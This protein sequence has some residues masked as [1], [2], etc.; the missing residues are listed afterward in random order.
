MLPPLTPACI[1]AECRFCICSCRARAPPRACAARAEHMAAAATMAPLPADAPNGEELRARGFGDD[2]EL[3]LPLPEDFS[4]D[5][6]DDDGADSEAG[7]DAVAGDVACEVAADAGCEGSAA[8]EPE[9]AWNWEELGVTGLVVQEDACGPDGCQIFPCC[10]VLLRWLLD[11]GSANAVAPRIA[12]ATILELGAGTGA[13][14]LALAAA[15][16]GPAARVYASEGYEEIFTLLR[17]NIRSNDLEDKVLPVHWDWEAS[18]EVPDEIDLAGVD[19]VVAADVVYVGTGERQLAR[20]LGKICRG[21]AGLAAYLM[22]ADRPPGGLEF[23]PREELDEE[24]IGD[25]STTAVE[26][27]LRACAR[28]CLNAERMHLP[29]GFVEDALRRSGGGRRPDGELV[30]YRISDAC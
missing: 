3:V 26:R 11:G 23:L 8:A 9:R 25:V 12:G 1:A 16:T 28:E 17:Q 29:P 27:F 18:Q 15:S 7:H 10:L 22:L 19:F 21:K 2:D 30:L 14:A 13:L 24:D 6:D 20:S 5:D 4:S